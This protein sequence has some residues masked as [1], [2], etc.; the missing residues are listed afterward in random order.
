MVRT[1]WAQDDIDGMLRN[2]LEKRLENLPFELRSAH[3]PIKAIVTHEN[4]VYHR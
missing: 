3:F 1:N 2:M 4:L